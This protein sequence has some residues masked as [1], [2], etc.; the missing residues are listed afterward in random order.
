MTA[1]QPSWEGR[2]TRHG[3]PWRLLEVISYLNRPV[4]LSWF[5]VTVVGPGARRLAVWRARP[6][7]GAAPA[8]A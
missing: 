3:G 1:P 4:G 8:A 2:I 5:A 6:T 7:S